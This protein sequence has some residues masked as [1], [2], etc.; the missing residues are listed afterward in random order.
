MFHD[1]WAMCT[2]DSVRYGFYRC[3]QFLSASVYL[4]FYLCFSHLSLLHT[5]VYKVVCKWWYM[6]SYIYVWFKLSYIQEIA[7]WSQ[8][9]HWTSNG[10]YLYLLSL[11]NWVLSLRDI[12]KFCIVYVM[13]IHDR[14]QFKSDEPSQERGYKALT[15]HG[16]DILWECS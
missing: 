1:Y 14:F 4:Y 7:K 13:S 8:I 10:H 5:Q 2:F 11:L 9:V 6:I 3:I 16:V 12:I 15:I